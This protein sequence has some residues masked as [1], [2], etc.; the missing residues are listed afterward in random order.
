MKF[1]FRFAFFALFFAVYSENVRGDVWQL[2]TPGKFAK[3]WREC[4]LAENN[5]Q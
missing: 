5:P 4:Y 2:M 1:G 3:K